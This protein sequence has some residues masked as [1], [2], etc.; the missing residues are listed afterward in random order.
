M[1]YLATSNLKHRR[2]VRVD[3]QVPQFAV[4]GIEHSLGLDKVH[5]AVASMAI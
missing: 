2:E 3:Q 5:V 4:N 1:K